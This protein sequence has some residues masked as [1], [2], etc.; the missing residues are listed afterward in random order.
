MEKGAVLGPYRIERE[1]GS[2]GMG[3]VYAAALERRAAGLDPGA[4]VALKVVHPHL[5]EAPGF[6]KRFLRVRLRD[7]RI[8]ARAALGLRAGRAREGRRVGR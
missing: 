2:G 3:T 5:V 7:T 4:T 8:S 6:F 1:L